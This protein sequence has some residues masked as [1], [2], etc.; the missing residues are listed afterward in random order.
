MTSRLVLGCGTFGR[1]LALDLGGRHEPLL[2]LDPDGGRVD[3]LRDEGIRAQQAETT[4]P[5][6]IRRRAT[7]PL[8]TVDTVVVAGDDPAENRAA[9]EAAN[10][11]FPDAF[12]LAYTGRNPTRT[13]RTAV[14]EVADDAVDEGTAT[15][16]SLR[17]RIDEPGHRTRR[18]R[19]VLR[20]LDGPLAVVA[21]DNPDPDAISS[22]VAL[23]RIAETA[24]LE[25]EVC[26]Y[27]EINHQ[28]NRAFVNLLDYDLTAL[29][30][31][32]E[33]DRFGSFAIV[34]HS[35]P[36][37]ND[38]LPPETEVSVVIDHHPP[39]APV[40]ARFVDLRS[41]VGATSTLLAGYLRDLGVDPGRELAT[42][43]LFGIRVDTDDFS[44]EVDPEDFR[45][46][47]FLHSFADTGALERIESPSMSPETM[48]AIAAAIGNREVRDDVLVTCLGTVSDRDALAQAADRL[49][50]LEGA[51]VTF[52]FGFTGVDQEAVV[53]VS[54]RA[55]GADLDLGEALRDAFGQVG[56]AGGHADMAGAQIPVGML[57]D[58]G[59][60]DPEGVIEAVVTE[61]FFDTLGVSPNRAA[62]AVYAEGD[63]IGT[64]E[65]HTSAGTDDEGGTG[66]S[67]GGPA[68]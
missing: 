44:R 22:A 28:E 40:E 2:V 30:A 36:G 12:L 20:S 27:G 25:A 13:D 5:G 9:A 7:D 41:N 18:L 47:A 54:A 21:H 35:R 15:A 67:E 6:A 1:R 66:A 62:T 59:D 43:L 31:E 56:S 52:V 39:R 10:E 38:G 19:R 50:D 53:Y 68:E 24:G 17:G 4:D 23:E 64:S 42:G 65:Y 29:D 37:V 8:E 58:E 34:D 45:A 63:Y 60:E 49:L 48:D 3:G 55:R 32:S 14:R 26:Y 51:S 57:I 11:A 61:R 33:L 16:E 46:A